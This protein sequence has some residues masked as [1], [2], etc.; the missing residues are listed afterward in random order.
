MKKQNVTKVEY[1]ESCTYCGRLIKGTSESQ[2]IYNLGVHINRK[3][4]KLPKNQTMEEIKKE[5]KK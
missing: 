1:S 3:H 4:K 5:V 2:L